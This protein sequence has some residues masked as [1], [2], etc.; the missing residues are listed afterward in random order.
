MRI[1]LIDRD[2]P[3]YF[4][5]L[6]HLLND[7]ESQTQAGGKKLAIGNVGER[8]DAA[9]GAHAGDDHVT[10]GCCDANQTPRSHDTA[11]IAWVKL[12]AGVGDEFPLPCP[13]CGGDIRLIAF[14]TEPGLQPHSIEY[15]LLSR[16]CG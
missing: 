5:S 7:C 13:G 15:C 11:R 9:T 6:E 12:V 14:I 10:G 8:G 3:S 4:Q 16:I 1:A 2:V